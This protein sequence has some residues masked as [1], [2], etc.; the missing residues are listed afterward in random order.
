MKKPRPSWRS[1]F[2]PIL[3]FLSINSYGQG[4]F[5]DF[6]LYHDT[7]NFSTITVNSGYDFKGG[8]QYFGFFNL[9]EDFT[10]AN[11]SS[12]YS[13]QHF[14]LPL[15]NKFGLDFSTL[16]TAIG[17]AG[18]S[19]NLKLGLR[20]RPASIP[21]IKRLYD[22]YGF[23]FFTSLHLIQLQSQQQRD[24]VPQVEY[25]YRV[26]LVK[27]KLYLFGF[28][29]QDLQHSNGLRSTWVTEHQLGYQ[30]K[31]SWFAVVEYRY[32]QYLPQSSGLGFGLEYFVGY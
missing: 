14:R 15:I 30:I 28:A 25:V 11:A 19:Q 26:Q 9:N 22:K 6:N 23:W 18:V 31:G 29:D 1:L 7:R 20:W 3:L 13:E 12:F 2:Y 5:T 10:S 4:G 32:N 21:A 24:F 17:G 27:D 8:S 16:L